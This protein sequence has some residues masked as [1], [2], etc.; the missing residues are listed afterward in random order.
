M[1]EKK[2][3]VINMDA[4]STAFF[5][6]ELEHV[7]TKTY[8][9]KKVPLR[10]REIFPLDFEVHDGANTVTYHQFDTFGIAKIISNYADDLPV[11]D[12]AG[13]EFTSNV[14]EIG[15]SFRYSF[16]DIRRAKL[17]NRPLET[18]LA[19]AARR[20]VSEKENRVAFFGDTDN[21]IPGILQNANIP[22]LAAGVGAGGS[23]FWDEKTVDEVLADMN[24]VVNTPSEL[25]SGTEDV[26]AIVLSNKAHVHVRSR[27]ADDDKKVTILQAFLNANPHIK[28]V[29]V[30]SELDNAGYDNTGMMMAYKKSPDYLQLVI[31]ME[32]VIHA[33]QERGLGYSVPVE[34]S[35]GGV[36]VYY[37]L[38]IAFLEGIW[39]P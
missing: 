11:V 20:A 3:K 28:H 34:Q 17:A 23:T 21:N 39:R 13:K 15:A 14:K 35:T 6:R 1:F 16:K 38:A 19:T 7:R 9:I 22:R 5:L 4:E 25:T 37:P 12:I 26:D 8:D 24:V 30:A 32:F 31:P 27:Y 2:E 18:R 36:V 10:A 33:P 29:H